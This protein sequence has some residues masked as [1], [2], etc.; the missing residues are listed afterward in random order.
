MHSE[1]LKTF[2]YAEAFYDIEIGEVIQEK[3]TIHVEA[4]HEL[5]RGKEYVFDVARLCDLVWE[6]KELKDLHPIWKGKLV[7]ME[8]GFGDDWLTIETEDKKLHRVSIDKKRTTLKKIH[9]LTEKE[10]QLPTYVF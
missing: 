8:E 6:G 4:Y 5:T 2:C 3:K 1:Q 10:E 7:D 9:Y